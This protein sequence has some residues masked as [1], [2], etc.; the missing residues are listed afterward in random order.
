MNNPAEQLLRPSE[1]ALEYVRRG[2][3][4]IPVPFRE[5]GPRLKGWQN[6]RINSAEQVAHY[7]RDAT[8]IG[9]ILA[10]ASGGLVDVDIDCAEAI[11][12]C[13]KILPKTGSVFGRGSKRGS[14]RLY[15]VG[16]PAPSMKLSDPINGNTLIELRGDKQDGTAGLQTIVPPSIHPSGE[17]IEW[18]EDAEPAL[19]EYNELKRCLVALATRVL[20]VRYCPGATT[21][22]E[23]RHALAQ[24]DP[25]IMEQ[26]AR[27]HGDAGNARS[28]DGAYGALRITEADI[29][30]LSRPGRRLLGE[31]ARIDHA[32]LQVVE[33]DIAW[34]WTALTFIPSRERDVWRDIGAAVHDIPGWPEELRRAIWDYWSDKLDV[35]P[36]DKEKKFNQSDQDATWRSFKRPYDRARVTLGTIIYRA[37]QAG[38]DE[39]TLK[40][41]PSELRRFLP[42]AITP[43]A[44]AAGVQPPSPTQA[45]ASHRS[46]A[47]TADAEFDAEIKRLAGLTFFQYEK[48]RQDAADRFDVRV[49]VLDK[50]VN[51]ERGDG[52]DGERQ[53]QALKLFEPEPWPDVVDGHALVLDIA[54][55]VRRFVVLPDADAFVIALWI[56]HDYAFDVFTCTPRLCVSSPEKGCGKTTLLDVIE[57]LVN[58]PLLAVNITGPAIFR[59]IEQGRPTLLFDEADN[60]FGHRGKADGAGDILA[61]LNSGHKQGGQTLR[62]V[63]VG[64]DFEPR[65]F[66]THAPVVLALI[67]KLPGTLADRSIHIR[68]RRKRAGDR[69]ELFR[70]DRTEDLQRLAR[71]VRRWSENNRSFLVTSDPEMPEGLF[72]RVAD[73]WRPLLAIADLTGWSSEARA[74][75]SWTAALETEDGL[76]VMLLADIR[77]HF[78]ELKTDRLKSY[79][80]VSHLNQLEGRPWGDFRRELGV[81]KRWVAKTLEPFGIRPE[82]E[83][84]YFADGTRDR[85]YLMTRFEDAWARY[86]PSANVH[87]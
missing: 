80:L 79:S 31:A 73:N 32:P 26:I 30:H 51:A 67:G 15:R 46:A 52:Q 7:F 40:P 10:A 57:C 33:R 72:N 34:V 4:V 42:D 6:L 22:D 24:A 64:D 11:E 69:V 84:I 2:W 76:G 50:L 29:A 85:G 58:R 68:L 62:A 59:A 17:P 37:R 3:A 27:W 66:R 35:P 54:K 14:H 43:D 41:L 9:V 36:P 18:V 78:D 53:G 21:A 74:V 25:R 23:A 71:Q 48:Q 65:A 47:A 38:W 87:A 20:I 61:I 19:I 39:H 8:N 83:A 60:T 16:G 70:M 45:T 86:L 1:I 56:L 63:A 49:G 81:S 77:Q 5:K 75:A 82:P 44:A 13:G 55:A 28:L 12:L